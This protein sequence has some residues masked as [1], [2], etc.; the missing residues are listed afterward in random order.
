MNKVI[1]CYEYFKIYHSCTPV[2]KW[3]YVKGKFIWQRS[4]ASHNFQ[5]SVYNNIVYYVEHIL[6]MC[7]LGNFVYN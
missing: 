5:D 4:N 7:S 1:F 3:K 6:D 2:F